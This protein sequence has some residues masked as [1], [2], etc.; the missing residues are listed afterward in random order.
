MWQLCG[1][2]RKKI[3]SRA[4]VSWVDDVIREYEL[5]QR[6]FAALASSSS[7]PPLLSSHQDTHLHAVLNRNYR[8]LSNL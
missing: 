3:N 8:N 2:R 6:L 1:R 5:R 4:R 7:L